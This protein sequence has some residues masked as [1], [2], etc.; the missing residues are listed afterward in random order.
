MNTKKKLERNADLLLEIA[1][2]LM[3]SGANTHRVDLN[4][5]R[6]ASALH[7]ESYSLIT[8]KTIILTIIDNETSEN[9]TK[10]K[11]LRPHK[12]DFAIISSISKTSWTALSEG[13]IH[14]RIAQEIENIKQQ[15]KYPR[16][17]ILS[18]VSFA[19]AGF[20]KIFGGDYSNVIVAFIST[21]FGL[22]VLQTAHKR[23]FNNYISVFLAS[24]TASLLATLGIYF[25]LG[26]QPEAALATSILFLVPGVA[27]INSFT[28]LIDK[29]VLNGMVRFTNGIMTVLAIALGLFVAMIIFHI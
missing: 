13:W 9:C 6:F 4:I 3:I 18:A 5:D 17:I 29:N 25:N 14:G 8:Q 12:I 15:K 19:G 22:L 20:C 27:L 11:N 21:F 28:D 16:I 23:N 1:E 10:V 7:C 26:I 24:L 2:V